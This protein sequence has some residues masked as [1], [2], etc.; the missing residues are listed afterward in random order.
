MVSCLRSY[1][2]RTAEWRKDKQGPSGSRPLFL[3]YVQPH[4]PVTSQ[5]IAHWVKLLLGEAGVDTTKFS[6]H[7]VRGA[8]TT[9][10]REKGGDLG[11][12][13]PGG[14]LEFGL[15][16]QAFLLSPRRQGCVCP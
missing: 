3:S 6:A 12:S 16:I 4:G 2:A 13:A 14:R 9:A 10:A 8:S 15:H 5:R 1:E 11:R 7:S